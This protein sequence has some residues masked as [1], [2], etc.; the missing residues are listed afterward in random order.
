M[1]KRI[2]TDFYIVIIC[3][4]IGTIILWCGLCYFILFGGRSV[5]TNLPQYLILSFEEYIEMEDGKIVV[6]DEGSRRLAEYDLWMQVIDPQGYVVAKKNTPN[7]IPDQYSIYQ[8]LNYSLSSDRLEGYTIYT[9][10]LEKIENYGLIIGCKSNV[11]TKYSYSYIGE[12]NDLLFKSS[13]IFIISMSCATIIAG[14]FFAKKICDPVVEIINSINN[15]TKSSYI[16]NSPHRN[17]FMDVFIQI[18]I[19][20]ERLVENNKVRAEWIANISHDIRTPLSTIKGYAEL[21]GDDEYEFS[22]EEIRK[23][24]YEISRASNVIEGF[25]DELKMSQMLQENRI[26]LNKEKTDIVKLIS[27]CIENIDDNL[28]GD[29][30][31]KYEHDESVIIECDN[32][33]LKRCVQNILCNAFVHNRKNKI[34]VKV[35]VRMVRNKAYITI[36]DDGK[37]MNEVDKK[38]VFERYYRGVSSDN[39]KG[40]GLGMAIAKE[41]VEAH[42]GKIDVLSEE[43]HGT[44]FIIII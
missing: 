26:V 43:N 41:I 33:L 30:I 40:T 29:S 22:I 38:H 21:M 31:I 20:H 24:S 39:I 16:P 15:L 18:N 13:L 44:Q 28:I 25:L 8:L 9:I 3:T 5:D 19:L 14:I 11:V 23:F 4:V 10:G 2:A 36:S 12:G 27:D 17:I 6:S 7:N 42:S 34:L 1:K 32:K 37:G 35:S